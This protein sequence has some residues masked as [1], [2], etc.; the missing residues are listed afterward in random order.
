M[1]ISSKSGLFDPHLVGSGAV[2][3]HALVQWWKMGY[4]IEA[5]T[6]PDIDEIPN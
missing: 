3:H 4:Q 2:A 5:K 1:L 6:L